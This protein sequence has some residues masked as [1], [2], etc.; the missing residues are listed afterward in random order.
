MLGAVELGGTKCIVAIGKSPDRILSKKVILTKDPESTF[1]DIVSFFDGCDIKK[2]GVGSFG[3]LILDS[4]SENYG[5]LV[6]ESKVGWNGVNV[7]QNLSN[8][9]SNICIDTDVNAAALGEYEYG[10]E[11]KC[12]TLVYVTVGTGIGVGILLNGKPSVGNFHLEIGH[13]R[14][15]PVDDFQ[16]VCNIHGN[17][18]EGLASGP[19]IESRWGTKA[20]IIPTSHDAWKVEA[21][22]LASGLINI[23][24]NHSPDKIILGGGVMNQKHLF[25]MIKKRVVKLWNNYTPINF[26]DLIIEPLLGKDSGIIGSLELAR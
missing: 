11:E 12:E 20:S 18:W 25:P 24:A 23:I 9:S 1:S 3:P 21:E 2:L 4:K 22:L 8:I 10:L 6:S 5:T 15:P 26:S 16:G 19:S 14:I 17:C 7:V 13:M